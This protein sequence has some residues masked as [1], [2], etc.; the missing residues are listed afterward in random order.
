MTPD[1]IQYEDNRKHTCQIKTLCSTKHPFENKRYQGISVFG[2]KLVRLFTGGYA[3]IYDLSVANGGLLEPLATFPLGSKAES[4]HAGVANF[5]ETCEPGQ[6]FPLLYV[7]GGSAKLPATCFVEQFSESEGI[8]T[9]ALI[10]TITLDQSGF[11]AAGLK[12][13]FPWSKWC[14][15]GDK[16][17]LVSSLMRANGTTDRQKNRYIVTEFY[18]PPAGGDVEL[19]ASDVLEQFTLPF[20]GE[21]GQGITIFKGTLIQVLGCPSDGFPAMAAFSSLPGRTHKLAFN[22]SKTQLGTL[23]L[24]DCAVYN[25]NLIIGSTNNTIFQIDFQ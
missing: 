22:L 10:Q 14:P 4:N 11:E 6:K 24:E 5:A 15:A 9:S 16:L 21:F 18:C 20:V 25:G 19:T 3:A 1:K 13:F 17:Y 23:E 8:Y 7:S 12:S 2:D